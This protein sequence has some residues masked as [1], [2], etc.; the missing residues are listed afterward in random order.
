MGKGTDAARNEA[1][2]HA[3]AIDDFKDQLLLCLINRLAKLTESGVVKVP[4][5]DVDNTGDL[6]LS[7]SVVDNEFNFTVNKK[8]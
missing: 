3:Q 8:H 5:S 2:E 4:V 6:T 7:M 1:P